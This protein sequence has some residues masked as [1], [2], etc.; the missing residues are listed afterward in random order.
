M[1]TQKA[2][3]AQDE[4][5]VKS[6]QGQ[7]DSAK[8]NLTYCRR[9]RRPSAAWSDCGWSIRA[10]SFTPAT[11][12]DCWSS[13][14]WIPSACCSRCPRISFRWCLQKMR[15][16][17]KLVSGRLRSRHEEEARRKARSPPSTIKSTRP[18]ERCGCAPPS[19]TKTN[20]LFPNQFVNARL[21]V[22]E[23]RGVVLLPNA[24]DSANRDRNIRVSGHSRDSTVTFEQFTSE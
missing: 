9:S 21:L 22:E 8:L 5:V 6:D 17:A 16:P 4:G 15:G 10:I 24:R 13:P 11:P 18:P 20:A 19:T 1:A 12:T 14:K 7:I 2:L 3:V 23:K